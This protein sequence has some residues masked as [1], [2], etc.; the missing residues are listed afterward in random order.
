MRTSDTLN[1]ILKAQYPEVLK[2]EDQDL[3]PSI[4][5]RFIRAWV[6][7]KLDKPLPYGYWAGEG[8]KATWVNYKFE[9]LPSAFCYDCGRVGHNNGS[10]DFKDELVPNRYGDHT[11]AGV[12]SPQAPTPKRPNQSGGR[13]EAQPRPGAEQSLSEETV[14]V[15]AFWGQIRGSITRERD[16]QQPNRRGRRSG[17]RGSR[18]ATIQPP[19]LDRTD[20]D[21]RFSQNLFAEFNEA[22]DLADAGMGHGGPGQALLI[23][24]MSPWSPRNHTKKRKKG[25]GLTITEAHQPAADMETDYANEEEAHYG[26][27]ISPYIPMEPVNQT[28]WRNHYGLE[29]GETSGYH[30]NNAEGVVETHKPPEEK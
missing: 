9:K 3:D 8:D 26:H 17:G 7:V 10:C 12:N 4:W 13:E 19:R 22:G 29:H 27:Y 14:A 28:C 23:Y 2:I 1:A 30:E 25:T 18:P 6:S 21:Q 16:G 11:R 15:D 20:G 24:N 5:V